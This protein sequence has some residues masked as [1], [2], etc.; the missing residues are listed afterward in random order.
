MKKRKIENFFFSSPDSIS[1]LLN[2]RSDEVQYTPIVLSFLI[3]NINQKSLLFLNNH[4]DYVIKKYLKKSIR[5]RNIRDLKDSLTHFAK[6]N[7]RITI[8]PSKTPYF[9]ES[10]LKNIG[11][12]IIYEKIFTKNIIEE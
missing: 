8:D 11:I 9:V 4:K 7:S 2:I 1:W 6:T 12:K 3:F 5:I 10:F